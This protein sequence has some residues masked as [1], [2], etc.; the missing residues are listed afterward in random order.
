LAPDIT[1]PDPGIVLDLLEAFRWSKTMFAA[2]SLG[3]FDALAAGPRTLAALAAD[4]KAQPDALGRLLDACVDLSL[5]RRSGDCYENTPAATTSRADC[6]RTTG[7]PSGP[8]WRRT[9]RR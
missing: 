2:V 9:S 6:W 5:L 8:R 1:K 3:V 7:T 4:L